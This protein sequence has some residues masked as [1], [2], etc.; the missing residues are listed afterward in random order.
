MQAS[1]YT[2]DQIEDA[3]LAAL[4]DRNLDAV[5]GL[6]RLLAVRAPRRA[7]AMKAA[8]D[9]GLDLRREAP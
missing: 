8:I 6:L 5:V 9:F 1:D 2:P 3:I 4:S 7:E